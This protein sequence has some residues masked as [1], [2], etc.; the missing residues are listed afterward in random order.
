M[1]F[2]DSANLVKERPSGV[3]KPSPLSSNRET[4]AWK[5]S[6]DEVVFRD[7]LSPNLSNVEGLSVFFE[8]MVVDCGCPSVE[9]VGEDAFKMFIVPLTLG[10]FPSVLYILCASPISGTLG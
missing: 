5:A 1:K 6:A 3:L 2:S 10:L 9:I 4:L 7:I 8:L